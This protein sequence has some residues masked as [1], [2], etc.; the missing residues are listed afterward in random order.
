MKEVGANEDYCG[1]TALSAYMNM[2]EFKEQGIKITIQ[3][4]KCL[5][6]PQLFT[7]QQGFIK[8]LSLIDFVM[9]TPP[10]EQGDIIKK[11]VSV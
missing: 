6:Y 8:D 3:E 9:N 1:G 4:W 7:K 11:G 2:D 10:N 5:E